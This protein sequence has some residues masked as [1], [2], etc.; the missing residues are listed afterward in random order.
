MKKGV[1]PARLSLTT[2]SS[3][4]RISIWCC[5]F[6]GMHAESVAS[7]SSQVH[8]L[9]DATVGV[10]RRV[11]NQAFAG[12]CDTLAAHADTD[13]FGARHQ[14]G[15]QVRHGGA[16]Y[17][18]AAGSVR[19]AEQFAHPPDHLPLHLDGNLIA[20]SQVGVQPGCQHLCQHAD[21]RPATVHPSHKAG[22]RVARGIR[23]NLAHERVVKERQIGWLLG[24]RLTEC[25]THR[26]RSGL[27][28][29]P[30]PDMLGVVQNIVEHTMCLRPECRANPT[31]QASQEPES[32]GTLRR[33]ESFSRQDVSGGASITDDLLSA[34]C[35][36][37]F[38][39]G[40]SSARVVIARPDIE[41]SRT[42][43]VDCGPGSR[44]PT[45]GCA[46]T[47]L[48]STRDAGAPRETA[49]RAPCDPRRQVL[50]ILDERTDP[51]GLADRRDRAACS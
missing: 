41:R 24:Q 29:R 15:D 3:S 50:R 43:G 34:E 33:R 4:A 46:P 22:M 32:S 44:P 9:S 7:Q 26:R 16:G 49:H 2:A 45:P 18:Q 37:N 11:G 10:R 51:G 1:R 48:Q 31:G 36:Q 19:K 38:S 20:P 27:P 35:S 28:D 23:Q 6:T 25:G 30:L 17:E 5:R 13:R 40:F 42:A 8:G 47:S 21:R 14:E 39:R 12:S